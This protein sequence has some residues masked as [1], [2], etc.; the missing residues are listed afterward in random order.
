M[1]MH[2]S[3]FQNETVVSA[4]T[5]VKITGVKITLYANNAIAAHNEYTGYVYFV[6]YLGTGRGGGEVGG[7]MEGQRHTKSH[8]YE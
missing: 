8:A 2:R 1:V 4:R 6:T 3:T 7:C 5:V